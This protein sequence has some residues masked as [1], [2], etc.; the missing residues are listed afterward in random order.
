M[1]NYKSP[2]ESSLTSQS[3]YM[4]IPYQPDTE[5]SGLQPTTTDTVMTPNFRISDQDRDS[6]P[7]PDRP[8]ILFKNQSE[9]NIITSSSFKPIPSNLQFTTELF[10]DSSFHPMPE[11]RVLQL[12]GQVSDLHQ[13]RD[14][15]G[16]ITPPSGTLGDSNSPTPMHPKKQH[17]KVGDSKKKDILNNASGTNLN[18]FLRGDRRHSLTPCTKSELLDSPKITPKLMMTTPSNTNVSLNTNLGTSS[19]MRST[20]SN[21]KVNGTFSG[22]TDKNRLVDQF[23]RPNIKGTHKASSSVDLTNFFR[24]NIELTPGKRKWMNDFDAM[25]LN[26][27]TPFKPETKLTDE[28]FH[29]ILNQGGFKFEFDRELFLEDDELINFVLNI[30]TIL[31]EYPHDVKKPYEQLERIMTSMADKVVIKSK[32]VLLR[33]Q[34]T[35]N[36]SL[37][38]LESLEQYLADLKLQTQDLTTQLSNNRELIRS[39]YREEIN[40]NINKLNQVSEQLKVLEERSNSFKERI[41]EENMAMSQ[42]MIEK[43]ELLENINIRMREYSRVKKS[44]RVKQLQVFIS[45]AVVVFL[46]FYYGYK[47]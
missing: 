45:V 36:K 23:Y 46:A 3:E 9:S 22:S 41:T 13:Q 6:E 1:N 26:S 32:N 30:D 47:R 15:L 2:R 39:K 44:R 18:V 24:S 11:R 35:K 4:S 31:D 25:D 37:D 7:Y 17:W 12:D 14:K 42:D 27:E 5:P 19:S 21:M 10:D 29:D 33:D 40:N 43:L 28:L 20:N 8:N 38:E 34:P 16:V